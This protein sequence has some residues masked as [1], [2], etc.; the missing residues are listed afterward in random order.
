MKTYDYEFIN[1]LEKIDDNFLEMSEND[2][3]KFLDQL[4]ERA[5]HNGAT[6]WKLFILSEKFHYQRNYTDS[7]KYTLEAITMSP[8]NYYFLSSLATTYYAME[9]YTNALIYYN[10]AIEKNKQ[11]YR[12]YI[13]RASVYRRIKNFSSAISDAKYVIE[14][15]SDLKM[16]AT[17]KQSLARSYI[18]SK[19]L[20]EAK[21]LLFSI[22]N[23]LSN[24]SEYY[25]SLAAYYETIEDYSTALNYY[26]QATK[27]C[28]EPTLLTILNAKIR[29]YEKHE[30]LESL[31]PVQKMM[32]K[33]SIVSEEDSNLIKILYE[34]S[35][36]Q[37][38][39]KERYK[40]HYLSS[41]QKRPSWMKDNYLLCLK[42]W[43][44]S[45][46][47]FSL[48][49]NVSDKNF[50]GGGL[51]IRWNNKGIVIDPGINFL[52]NF[53]NSGLYAQD[54]SYVIVTHNHIDHNCDLNAIFDLDYQL[55]LK[56]HYY[57]DEST[58]LEC[59]NLLKND[60]SKN[61]IHCIFFPALENVCKKQL[62]KSK[63]DLL[64]FKTFHNC[65]G[66]YGIKLTLQGEENIVISYTS[67]TAFNPELINHLDTSHVI[68]ANF[69]ETNKDDLFLRKYKT[70][71]LGLNGCYSILEGLKQKP[72]IFFLSEFWGGLGDIRIEISKRLKSLHKGEITVIP[73]DIGMTCKLPDLKICC[74]SCKRHYTSNEIH[75]LKPT[76]STSSASLQY[77]CRTCMQ[78]LTNS[79][80]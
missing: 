22:E 30:C 64:A 70:D 35:E 61:R 36:Q 37:L 76:L 66:S 47:E 40:K 33:L 25:E 48:G 9:D 23:E 56:L 32:A 80:D 44:S 73:S 31:D 13:D 14:H 21:E 79:D 10:K 67:D 41:K 16:I 3:I 77:I 7:L 68:I 75:I 20:P 15:A 17:A 54:I 60:D 29:I 42:G 4:L 58:Y 26:K 27:L 62:H 5:V 38:V 55:N 78:V 65:T 50:K 24:S 6:E 18:L 34:H 1:E 12:A 57:L 63:I 52:E 43:S 19:K 8:H 46:P 45:T 69:S 53:H 11:F 59:T 74:S 51:Y 28:N 71:H 72:K 2:I 39:M 49:R